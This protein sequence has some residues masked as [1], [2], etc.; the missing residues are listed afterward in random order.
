M[1]RKITAMVLTAAM[2]LSMSSTVLAAGWQKNNTGWWWQ[3]DNGTYPMNTWKW[4]D[5]NA[6]GV[7]ECYYFDGNGYCL[8]NTRIPDGYNVNTDGAWVEGGV[9][10]TQSTAGNKAG[11]TNKTQETQTN[12][13]ADDYSGVYMVPWYESENN[14]SNRAVTLTYDA[15][16]NTIVYY[17]PI[18]NYKSTYT[19]FGTGLNGWTFFELETEEEKDAIFFSAPGVLEAYA[20]DGFESVHRN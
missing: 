16:S 7:S 4:L 1:K 19:Y 9:V 12:T 10:Q 11:D 18:S 8:L 20:W 13:Y 3:E 17:E 15:A 14:R 5:G 6:D 2:A